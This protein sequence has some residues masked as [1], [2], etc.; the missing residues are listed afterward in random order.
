MRIAGLIPAI[1]STVALLGC[2]PENGESSAPAGRSSHTIAVG[3][4]ERTFRLYRPASFAP[5][6]ALVVM[7]HGGFGTASQ[8]QAAYGWDDLAE[9]EGFVV[10]YPDGA[11]RA[12]AVGGGCCGK[13]GRAGTDDVAFVTAL[14]ARIEQMAPIDPGRVFATGMSNGAM[15][16]YRLACDTDLFAAIGPVAGTMLGDC[17]SPAPVSVIHIHGL[18]DQSVRVDGGPGDGF[19]R[20]DG[21]ALFD[22]I[23]HWR[24]ANRCDPPVEATAALVTTI[25]AACPRSRSVQLITIAGAGHQWPGAAGKPVM[26]RILGTDQPSTALDATATIWRFFAAHP[27]Q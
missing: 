1:A 14:V 20:I 6:S 4:Q 5:G 19:A 11:D 25:A 3:G 15:M 9:R 23:D 13:P 8:A 26:E 22:V 12:W 2:A 27:R 7:L 16:S 21:P 18:A 10:A 24:V 17:P